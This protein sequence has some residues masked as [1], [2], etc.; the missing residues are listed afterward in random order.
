[1]V[2]ETQRNM[3][4]AWL[5]NAARTGDSSAFDALYD[6]YSTQLV[7]FCARQLGDRDEGADV[8]QDAFLIAS[9]RLAQLD[10]PARFRSW[11]YVIASRESLR[12][13]RARAHAIPVENVA[14]FEDLDAT[15]RRSPSSPTGPRSCSPP[16]TG[17]RRRIVP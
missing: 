10:D 15:P 5:V 12:R 9:Q 16:P 17:W 8:M 4:D 14:E 13:I 1:M 3:P 6:R 11:L 2:D 7:Q